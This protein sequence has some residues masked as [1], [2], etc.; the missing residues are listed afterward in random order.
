MNSALELIDVMERF[1]GKRILIIGDLMIDHY[2]LG[3]VNRIS[4]EAPI[5]IV[6][7]S[8]Y[9]F[10]L[11]GAANVV[12]CII[13]M[14]GEPL[15]IGVVGND[16]F[17]RW[18]IHQL[19]SSGVKEACLLISKDR[20]TT[21]K[22][23]IVVKGQHLMRVD[24]EKRNPIDSELMKQIISFVKDKMSDIDG[25]IISDYEKGVVTINLLGKLIPLLKKLDVCIVADARAGNLLH[26]SGATVVRTNVTYSSMA[27]GI[28]LINETSLRNIGLNLLAHLQCEAVV[29]TRGRNGMSIFEKNGGLTHIP[30][31]KEV[32]KDITGAGDVVVS[33]FTLAMVS[34][35]TVIDA[36]KLANCAAGIKVITPGT[37]TV[38]ADKLKDW[39]IRNDSLFCFR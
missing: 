15:P 25:V 24:H 36:A 23:R 37:V 19:K 28:N 29:I 22:T 9:V 4:P 39:L 5:P 17:G 35:A 16:D 33:T 2:I 11:G 20:P 14:G 26:Y 31:T 6:D 13:N 7:A 21:T 10:K 27:T 32:A 18:M 12:N 30:A 38:S 8:S 3:D 1:S 34:G